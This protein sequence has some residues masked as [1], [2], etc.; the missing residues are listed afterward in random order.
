M[1]DNTSATGG[2]LQPALDP[3]LLQDASE[4]VLT[5]LVSGVTGLPGDLVRPRWQEKPPAQPSKDTDWCGVGI[6]RTAAEDGAASVVIHD[7]AGEGRDILRRHE[8]VEV[9]ASFYGPN[10]A[11][12]A[13]LLRDGLALP[14]NREPMVL[15][16]IGLI[17][18]GPI[19]PAA[20]LVNSTWLRRHDLT[21]TLRRQTNRIY[22]IRNLTS[23][24][25]AVQAEDVSEPWSTSP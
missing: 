19:M 5:A 23:A 14:Q 4:D 11:F 22:A 20:E 6:T 13:T 15:A 17:D 21:L 7:G 25:G 16:D 2:P 8:R 24:A 18:I 3:A 12:Y 9:M 1:P 10:S